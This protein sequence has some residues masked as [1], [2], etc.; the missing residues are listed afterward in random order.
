MRIVVI[1]PYDQAQQDQFRAAAGSAELIFGATPDSVRDTLPEA[2][3]VVGSLPDELLAEAPHLRWLHSPA[4]GVDKEL[5]PRMLASDIVLTS[6]AGN[7]GIPL[8]EHAMLLMLM[9]NRNVPR[10]IEAQRNRTWDRFTHGE[11][12]GLTVGII[13]LGHAGADLALKAQAFHMRVLGLRRRTHLPTPNVDRLYRHEELGEFLAECDFVAVTAPRTPET[14]GLLGRD[15]FAVMK[16][17]SYVV[18]ISR[19][20]IIDD[21]ALLDALNQGQI[22]G[23]GL[24]AHGTEPLPPDSP[25]WSQPNVIVTPH[26]GATTPGTARRGREIVAENLRRFASGESLLNVVDKTAGY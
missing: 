24:D 10:W 23:A 16:P 6:S 9:L 22:A 8:A 14:A 18:C 20:G 2:E 26:N 21:D 4:A 5:T 19:G 25:F 15:A 13:G 12:N 3:G 1:G 7:G 17:T 11:L